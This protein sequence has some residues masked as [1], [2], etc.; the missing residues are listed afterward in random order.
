MIELA[1]ILV[2][3]DFSACSHEA[4]EYAGEL[5][6]RFSADL[7][8]LH[9]AEDL[10]RLLP[11]PGGTI[12]A[13]MLAAAEAEADEALTHAAGVLEKTGRQVHRSVVRGMPFV[14]IIRYAREQDI[15]L[16]VI[17]T[18]GRTGLQQALM[19]SVAERVVRK[20]SCPVLVV[21]ASGHQ[22]VMP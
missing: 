3:T 4:L 15:D 13:E 17:G 8:L 2:A 19:G 22:F 21:R 11:H 7:H 6:K 1:R 5:A 10:H 14:E 9:V 20:A 16:I 18:H 12:P